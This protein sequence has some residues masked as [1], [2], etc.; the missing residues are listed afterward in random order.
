MKIN[1]NLINRLKEYNILLSDV[2]PILINIYYQ[3]PIP[4]YIPKKLMVQ[5]NSIGIYNTTE[6]GII[7]SI[8]LYE[9]VETTTFDWVKTEYCELFKVANKTK[10]GDKKAAT[11]RMKKLFSEQPDIRKDEIIGATKLYLSQT[12]S[13]YIRQSHYFISKG[14]GVN[15]IQ[16]I[17]T[18]IEEYRSS[19]TTGTSLNN[20]LQ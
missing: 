7:W 6:N 3:L 9:G 4:K 19:Q 8:P 20:I 5:V 12:D 14:K 13:N 1:E 18:W 10:V 16:D 11:L 15:M 17:L 2:L